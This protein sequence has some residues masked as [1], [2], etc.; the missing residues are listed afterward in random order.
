MALPIWIIEQKNKSKK[1]YVCPKYE[2]NNRIKA[3]WEKEVLGMY[4]TIHPME[5]YGFKPLEAIPDGNSGIQ[6]GVNL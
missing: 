5:K 1:K 3:E 2:W 4:L 6:G